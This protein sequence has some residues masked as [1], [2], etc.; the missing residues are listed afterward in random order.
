[1]TATLFDAGARLRAA[2]EQRLVPRMYHRP[3]A[4]DGRLMLAI[5]STTMGRGPG[6]R[7]VL[8]AA[9]S[10]GRTATGDSIGALS[11]LA[12]FACDPDPITL[13]VATRADLDLLL[14]LA[15]TAADTGREGDLAHLINVA[16][17]SADH[18]GSSLVVIA[19]EACAARWYTGEPPAHDRLLSTWTRWLRIASNGPN[20]LLDIA[21]KVLAGP[22]LPGEGAILD[23]D[24]WR[25]T[26]ARHVRE[27]G[28]DWRRNDSR[29]MAAIG[30]KSR[31][32]AAELHVG[33]LLSDPYLAAREVH[34]GHVVTGHVVESRKRHA[35]VSDRLDCRLKAGARVEG[36]VGTPRQSPRS[37]V[38]ESDAQGI[39]V[40]GTVETVA[41]TAAG[42]LEIVLTGMRRMAQT[43]EPLVIPDTATMTLRP[44]AADPNMQTRGRQNLRDRYKSGASWLVGGDIPAR[45]K[46][47]VPLDVAVAAAD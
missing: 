37:D 12:V 18:P 20:A 44:A 7:R 32:D 41:I 27:G 13:V 2:A 3:V 6:A 19:T 24:V 23:A 34:N 4:A 46:R 26:G 30:L 43:P 15:K 38:P 39:R 8:R 14:R 31:C 11:T 10:D 22:A 47:Q 17:H 45:P 36:W 9:M 16:A 42:H 40:K 5:A 25:W 35:L 21:E 29:M 1:M 33:L 28:G